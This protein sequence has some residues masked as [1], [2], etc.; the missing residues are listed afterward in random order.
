MNVVCLSSILHHSIWIVVNFF[1]YRDQLGAAE[2]YRG[3]YKPHIYRLVNHMTNPNL[4][5]V[6]WH[7]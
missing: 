7:E 5:N 1:I 6:N 3:M 4:S 2:M